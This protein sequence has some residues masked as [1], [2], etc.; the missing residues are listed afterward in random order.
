MP[1]LIKTK[2][3][4][5]VDMTMK[6]MSGFRKAFIL[7]L[8]SSLGL[9][10]LESAKPKSAYALVGLASGSPSTVAV[11]AL[12]FALGY[13]GSRN[14]NPELAGYFLA[15]GFIILD[16][17]SAFPRLAAITPSLKHKLNLSDADVELINENLDELNASFESLSAQMVT[18]HDL[19]P[20]AARHLIQSWMIPG[21]GEEVVAA[22]TRYFEAASCAQSS[23]A[24]QKDLL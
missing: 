14:E 3:R 24:G 20:E 5:S 19:R 21:L 8:A 16:Q 17:K 7:G 4:R 10:V 9:L 11:G 12:F 22:T 2:N 6:R 13:V 1:S 18:T 15:L 23:T